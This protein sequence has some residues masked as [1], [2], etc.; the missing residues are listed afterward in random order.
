MNILAL[1]TCMAACSAA[2]LRQTGGERHIARRFE[3]MERGHAEALFPMI[4]AVMSEA[5]MAFAELTRVAVTIGPGTFTGV[6]A[7]IAAARGI[8]LAARLPAVGAGSLEVMAT[9]AL[10]QLGAG[11]LAGGFMVA[12]DARR[13]EVYVQYF[14]P[15]ARALTPAAI[16]TVAEAAQNIPREI[17]AI[18]GSGAAAVTAHL[19]GQDHP[20][21]AA[22]LPALLPD[23]AD[24]AVIALNLPHCELPPVPLYLRAPDAKPQF[25]KIFARA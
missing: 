16:M 8:A 23:A 22:V 4:E 10:R 12:H 1:D 24:L 7:G 2:V 3:P 11:T 15:A 6:R 17:S 25:D 5:G 14:D 9:G 13:D 18:V 19:N 20:A 21:R